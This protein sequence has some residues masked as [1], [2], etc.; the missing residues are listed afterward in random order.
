MDA[1][2]LCSDELISWRLNFVLA[3]WGAIPEALRR[4]AFEHADLLRWV[5]P[6]TEFLAEMRI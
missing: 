1:C 4:K 2:P 5:G 6:N 3:N